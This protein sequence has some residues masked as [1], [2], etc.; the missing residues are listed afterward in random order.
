MRIWIDE[1]LRFMEEDLR[2]LVELLISI[3]ID[4][5]SYFTPF[6]VECGKCRLKWVT[7]GYFRLEIKHVFCD[8]PKDLLID[9]EIWDEDDECEIY[10][11][12]PIIGK[13]TLSEKH[14]KYIK[15]N[16]KELYRYLLSEILVLI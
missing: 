9:I 6:G 15:E 13:V 16:V 10:I 5:W 3:P 12:D 11:N 4:T 1:R 14:K 7:K 2:K 8:N